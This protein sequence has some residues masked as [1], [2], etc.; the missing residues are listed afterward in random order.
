MTKA[1]TKQV[2]EYFWHVS[3]IMK[4]GVSLGRVRAADDKTAIVKAVEEFGYT[5]DVR[6]LVA[7]READ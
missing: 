3:A 1:K 6:R 7:Q 2:Q 5:G 4:K